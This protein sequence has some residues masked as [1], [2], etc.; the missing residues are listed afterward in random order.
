MDLA[1]NNLQRL[2]CH[3]IPTTNQQPTHPTELIIIH[4]VLIGRSFASATP[5][6]MYTERLTYFFLHFHYVQMTSFVVTNTVW[7]TKVFASYVVIFNYWHIQLFNTM[8]YSHPPQVST[9]QERSEDLS[10]DEVFYPH[11]PIEGL[12]FQ[13]LFL[14]FICLCTCWVEF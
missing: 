8:C 14:V 11:L 4:V 13:L 1:L 6:K 2:I 7:L 5:S 9:L 3:K 12:S 10:R